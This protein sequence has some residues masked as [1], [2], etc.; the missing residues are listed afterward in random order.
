MTVLRDI[1][2]IIIHAPKTGGSSVRWPAIHK[3]GLR[4]SCQHCRH[5]Y[6][7]EI[8]KDFRK[9]TFIRNPIDWYR[10]RYTYDKMRYRTKEARDQLTT[11]L[12]NFYSKSFEQTL[13]LMLEPG[14]ALRNSERLKTFR[15]MVKIDITRRYTCWTVSYFNDISKIG[16]DTFGDK[17]Y[18]EWLRDI[19]GVQLVD[20]VYRIEDEYEYGMKKEF[21]E[22][23]KLIHR[24]KTPDS[25]VRSEK[26]TK[27]MK[28]SII[29]KEYDFMEKYGYFEEAL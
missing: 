6:L 26:Y 1:D 5:D 29:D 23:I 18:Y 25:F 2:T 21:G 11:V 13:P 22:D 3:F 24:N 28:R 9:M 19:V 12:S 7:P 10:S 14:E 8:Y 16:P 27:A 15:E 20:G 4:Y 17:T